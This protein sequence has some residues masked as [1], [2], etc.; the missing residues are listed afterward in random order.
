[1]NLYLNI[2]PVL[3]TTL[4]WPLQG[5]KMPQ[6]R[7]NLPFM[8]FLSCLQEIC[9]RKLFFVNLGHLS[10]TRSN[11]EMIEA[12]KSGQK[13][14]IWPN[15]AQNGQKNKPIKKKW[16]QMKRKMSTTEQNYKFECYQSAHINSEPKERYRAVQGPQNDQK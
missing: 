12:N 15:L 14:P 10:N 5:C 8:V 3:R 4:K 6:N 11:F 13:W 2:R 7:V 1:M 9:G 16:K